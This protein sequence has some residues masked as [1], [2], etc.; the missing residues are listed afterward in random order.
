MAK[1]KRKLGLWALVAYYFSTIVGVGIFLVPMRTAKI[2]G[3]ASIISWLLIL[4]LSYPFATIFARIAQN[5]PVS[6]SIPRFIQEVLGKKLGKTIA[7]FFLITTTLG[8]PLLGIEAARNIQNLLGSSDLTQMYILSMVIMTASS[9][10]NM[11]GIEISSRIQ[12]IM[13]A[14][15]IIVIVGT[16]FISVPKAE[17]H[18]FTPF[19]PHG[20]SSILVAATLSFYSIVGWENVSAIAEEVK[21]PQKTF[22]R[23][24]VLALILIAGFYSLIVLTVI[25]VLPEEMLQGDKTILASLLTLSIS[26]EVGRV[27]NLIT[28]C[29]LFLGAN[30]WILGSSRLMFS[31][32][33]ERLLP[34]GIAQVNVDTGIPQNAVIVQWVGYMIVFAVMAYVGAKEDGLVSTCSLNYML[35]YFIVFGCA[36]IYFKELAM[37]ILSIISFTVIAALLPQDMDSLLFSLAIFLFCLLYVYKIRKKIV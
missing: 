36:I 27:G 31:L 22:N 10:F 37:K 1:L 12:S 26:P 4:F 23:A 14:V 30:V 9:L 28:F 3:P 11:L 13:L 19:A 34:K 18:H 32:A 8:N 7:F 29:L 25:T 20:L 6:D 15:L 33:R 17:M 24:I 35:L 16:M 2:A 21:N 5:F